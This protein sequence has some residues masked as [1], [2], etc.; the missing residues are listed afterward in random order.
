[1]NISWNLFVT[2]CAMMTNDANHGDSAATFDD[3]PRDLSALHRDASRVMNDRDLLGATIETGFK[4]ERTS[5]M[6]AIIDG[7]IRRVHDGPG[8]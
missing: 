5:G 6:T 8:S 7:I 1:M 3:D 2:I 4:E